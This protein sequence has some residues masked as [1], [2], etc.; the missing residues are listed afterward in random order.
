MSPAELGTERS[1]GQA[2]R[3]F[4]V[5]C[6][7][8]KHP[9][10]MPA[11]ELYRSDWFLHARRYVEAQRDP[12]FILSAE[13]GLVHP[14]TVIAPYDRTLLNLT[15]AEREAWGQRVITQLDTLHHAPAVVFL[16]GRLYR[17]PLAL[18]AADRAVAPLA[19]LG[20]GLQ[21]QWLARQLR[22]GE[23]AR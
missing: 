22:A 12:W 3:L 7:A 20:I 11:R 9:I 13:H 10:P 19:R 4:L 15:R 6:V 16:A 21:K 18:W 1:E 17:D 5:S 8:A 23:P 2:A 14:D